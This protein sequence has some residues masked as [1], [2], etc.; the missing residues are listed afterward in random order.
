MQWG[1]E[2]QADLGQLDHA[3]VTW[4]DMMGCM[5]M[6]VLLVGT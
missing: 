5:G 4:N 1:G 2:G 6:Y 3:T